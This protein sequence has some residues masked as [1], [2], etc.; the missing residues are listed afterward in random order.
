MFTV[1]CLSLPHKM[2]HPSN[3]YTEMYHSKSDGG[4]ENTFYV[5]SNCSCIMLQFDV[6]EVGTQNTR[7]VPFCANLKKRKRKKDEF[8]G[9][10][11]GLWGFLRA[12]P[13]SQNSA[14]SEGGHYSVLQQHYFSSRGFNNFVA[15]CFP[16]MLKSVCKIQA[17]INC[18]VIQQCYWLH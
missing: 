16:T 15:Q 17:E 6:Q 1:K 14:V 5:W 12:P 7:G 13:V 8:F 10:C 4:P 3:T 2:T 18:R 11:L 9:R